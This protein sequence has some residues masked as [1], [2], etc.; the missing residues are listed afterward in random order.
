ME[1]VMEEIE[2]L[3]L[4]SETNPILRM[5]T[6]VF[7]FKNPP[8]N[9]VILYRQMANTMLKNNGIG[10]AAPQVGLP[11]RMFVMRTHPDVIGVFN[12]LLLDTS[13][14][15]IILEEGC[16]SFDMLFIKVKRPKRIRVRFTNPDGQT[17]TR[18]FDGM[19]A[20]CF[21][22]EL[23][24]LNGITYLQKANKF[25]IETAKKR[26]KQIKEENQRIA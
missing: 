24:H 16:L 10:L 21:L 17:E 5:N 7:D 9:P 25:H 3:S 2:T 12:P 18:V 1:G 13:E 20:R 8:T 4:V 11:Y 23:D 26:R 6:E 19:T 14:E 15:T 22:H